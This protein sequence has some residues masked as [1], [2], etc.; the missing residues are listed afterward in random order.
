MRVSAFGFWTP[1]FAGVTALGV[2]TIASKIR[3]S[4]DKTL[5]LDYISP[6]SLPFDDFPQ[7]FTF[8]ACDLCVCG[9]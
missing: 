5:R 9:Q 2:F 6:G 1:A 8:S 3:H 7:A 4:N